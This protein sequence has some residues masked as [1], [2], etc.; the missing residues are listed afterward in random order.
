M[1]SPHS[2]GG[3]GDNP[4]A[5]TSYA[6]GSER[7]DGGLATA[8]VTAFDQLAAELATLQGGKSAGA[9]PNSTSAIVATPAFTAPIATTPSA[10]TSAH[11]RSVRLDLKPE[12]FKPNEIDP[13]A[14]DLVGWEDLREQALSMI[15]EQRGP[16]FFWD[17]Q[18]QAIPIQP[19]TEA[20]YHILPCDREKELRILIES[21]PRAGWIHFKIAD[22]T[23]G[24]MELRKVVRSDGKV[25]KAPKEV[26]VGHEPELADES[27][28]RLIHILDEGGV[29]S[30]VLQ[31]WAPQL[32]ERANRR[33]AEAAEIQGDG[34][35]ISAAYAVGRRALGKG[36]PRRGGRR[37]G[38][39]RRKL[40]T[41]V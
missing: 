9:W 6:P 7:G 13:D 18:G 12:A 17:D 22:P 32:V 30:Y 21:P 41:V 11:P 34:S 26:W 3:H 29:G 24:K 19:V 2:I 27:A 39:L 25:L 37:L 38:L 8:T 14:V 16:D 35:G 10:S 5:G 20:K 1:N 4:G 31:F 36:W 23:K 40:P 15:P 33:K 28:G